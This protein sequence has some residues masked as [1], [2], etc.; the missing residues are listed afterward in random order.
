M[1]FQLLK[2]TLICMLMISLALLATA[3][4]AEGPERSAVIPTPPH[5]VLERALASI[6]D[7][8]LA[9]QVRPDQEYDAADCIVFLGLYRPTAT[10]EQRKAIDRASKAWRGSLVRNMG[11]T[12]AQQMIGSSV[13]P[14]T[15]TPAP[16]RQAAAAWCVANAP[17]Q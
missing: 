5:D 9:R 13:N 17:R 7:P 6:H 15:P 3:V 2:F 8:L 11:E 1:L 16:L 10:A 12:D 4:G 14:L